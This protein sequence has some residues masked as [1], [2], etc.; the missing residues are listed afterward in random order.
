MKNIFLF[1]L[2]FLSL[3]FLS[4]NDSAE[5]PVELKTAPILL[6]DSLKVVGTTE[7]D[8]SI[9][10]LAYINGEVE[11]YKWY[12]NDIL[13]TDIYDTLFLDSLSHVDSG[14]YKLIISN[15]GGSD[16]SDTYYLTFDR[17]AVN[18]SV[19]SGQSAM[20]STA[21]TGINYYDYGQQIIII[22]TVN[23]GYEFTFWEIGS[24]GISQSNP[25]TL[26]IRGDEA[27][28]AN[29]QS[30]LCTLSIASSQYGSVLFSNVIV[31]YDTD[32]VITVS[33]ERGCAFS[34]WTNP[35]GFTISDEGNGKYRISNITKNGSLT[36]KFAVVAAVNGVVYVDKNANR[37]G[38]KDGTSWYDAYTSFTK[39]L[40]T[41]TEGKT[42]WIAEGV[43]TPVDEMGDPNNRTLKFILQ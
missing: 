35:D 29:F 11:Q 34:S 16:T 5:D 7:I 24:S 17:H 13:L 33:A 21:P 15:S 10:I 4:C 23:I 42:F 38:A 39:A 26:S 43:Y 36:A 2:L 1:A 31:P 19:K 9:F 8:S 22:A 18:I 3:A 6:S 12:K 27:I 32:T 40:D 25:C 14:F 37:N 41:E 20:G 30:N 28:T